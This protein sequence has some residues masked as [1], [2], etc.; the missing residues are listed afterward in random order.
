VRHI[1]GGL[2]PSSI[3]QIELNTPHIGALAKTGLFV[4]AVALTV[5]I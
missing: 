5:S 2:N 1:K 3:N 4:A